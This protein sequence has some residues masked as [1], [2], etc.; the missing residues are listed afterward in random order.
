MGGFVL[1][2]SD[3]F[4]A[5]R[6]ARF[7]RK[8]HDIWNSVILSTITAGTPALIIL[9][10]IPTPAK[11]LVITPLAGG[12]VGLVYVVSIPALVPGGAAAASIPRTANNTV[13]QIGPAT[14]TIPGTPFRMDNLQSGYP[15][16]MVNE[17]EID[18]GT[19]NTSVLVAW[20][21]P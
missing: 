3:G 19:T 14:A 11:R 6:V 9:S 10:G 4:R 18:V 8:R 12:T 17:Y 13:A 16:I 20:E 21:L 15:P 7:H 1:A 2:I 5:A